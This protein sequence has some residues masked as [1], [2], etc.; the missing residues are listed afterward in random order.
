M[1]TVRII[2]AVGAAAPPGTDI[3]MQIIHPGIHGGNDNPGPGITMGPESRCI[4]GVEIPFGRSTGRGWRGLRQGEDSIKAK[5]GDFR[6]RGKFLHLIRAEGHR[7]P[8]E[9][10]ERGDVPYVLFQ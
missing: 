5:A 6:A 9:Y 2:P 8:V 10:P 3:R 7:H 4:D 1:F